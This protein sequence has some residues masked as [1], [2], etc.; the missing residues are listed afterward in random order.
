MIVAHA[1]GEYPVLIEAG[2]L[3]Q[4]PDLAAQYLPRRRTA[5]ITDDTVGR[6]YGE[7][8]RGENPAWSTRERS[9]SDAES[10]GWRER[11]SFPPGEQHKTRE[12][13]AE[14]TDRLVSAGYGRD[15]GVVALGGGVVGDIAGFVAATFARGIPFIQVP[16]TLLAM[17]DASVGGKT[18]V[19][20]PGGKNLVGSFHQP[21]A[22]LIDPLTLATLPEPERL[23][24]VV[25][26][27]STDSWQTRP[28]STGS[29]H[30]PR[31]SLDGMRRPWP[32]W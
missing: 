15:S 28:T 17:V 2:L 19:D 14:L 6:L 23:G 30:R 31:R 13:W 32:S 18:G 5:L 21:T 24:G 4:L 11:L 25:E 20:V 3:A 27:S 1:G 16:T 29:S 12:T 7:F 10:R 26:D 9:C 8:L 22:V